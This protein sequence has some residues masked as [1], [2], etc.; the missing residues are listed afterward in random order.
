MIWGPAPCRMCGRLLGGRLDGFCVPCLVINQCLINA[1]QSYG[2]RVIC[3]SKAKCFTVTE[4]AITQWCTGIGR[5][6]RGFGALHSFESQLAWTHA[7]CTCGA[8][9]N[10]LRFYVFIGGIQPLRSAVVR[11]SAVRPRPHRHIAVPLPRPPQRSRGLSPSLSSFHRLG[12]PGPAYH[13]RWM[14]TPCAYLV[15][16]QC[17]PYLSAY[18]VILTPDPTRCKRNSP[19]SRLRNRKHYSKLRTTK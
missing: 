12:S 14:R 7:R 15:L 8:R 10:H 13:Q 3:C 6:A 2:L 16:C 1:C 17:N 4:L 18:H 5:C 11:R 9:Q 19:N